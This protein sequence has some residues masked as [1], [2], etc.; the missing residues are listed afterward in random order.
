MGV[1]NPDI[2]GFMAG[3]NLVNTTLA[4]V[5]PR[6]A[7]VESHPGTLNIGLTQDQVIEVFGHMTLYAGIAFA[8]GRYGRCQRDFHQRVKMLPGAVPEL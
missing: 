3:F 5:G 7:P 2:T 1:Y 8:P 4:D 6:R